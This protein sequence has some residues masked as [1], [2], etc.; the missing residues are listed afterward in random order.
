VCFKWLCVF[1]SGIVA[2]RDNFRGSKELGIHLI[3]SA[4]ASYVAIIVIYICLPS[5]YYPITKASSLLSNTQFLSIVL[6]HTCV[7]KIK[8]K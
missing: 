6:T 7:F 3:K 2:L 8:I 1:K 4:K 5:F